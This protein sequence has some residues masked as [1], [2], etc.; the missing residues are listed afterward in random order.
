ML[1]AG[2]IVFS[3]IAVLSIVRYWDFPRPIVEHPV[4]MSPGHGLPDLGYPPFPLDLR[5]LHPNAMIS[6]ETWLRLLSSNTASAQRCGVNPGLQPQRIFADPDKK[7]WRAYKPWDASKLGWQRSE[8]SEYAVLWNG[9]D[10][11]LLVRT[12]TPEDF[13]AAKPFKDFA[14]STEY[15]FNKAGHLV[16]LSFV[17]WTASGWGYH[18]Q[19]PIVNGVVA[20]ETSEFFDEETSAPIKKP[21][22]ADDI[23]DALKPR[24]YL[25]KSQLPFSKMLPR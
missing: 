25:M 22:H 4:E 11:N 6:L 17:L 21:E 14:A 23:A 1:T 18:Q 3:L 2:A 13:A 7:T 20:T 12:A 15:C 5:P 9:H 10:G 24:L 8:W 16:Q 19:S